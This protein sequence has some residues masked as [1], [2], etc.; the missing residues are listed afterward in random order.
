[1]DT[2]PYHAQ[3]ARPAGHRALRRSAGAAFVVGVTVTALVA[4]V[5]VAA[6]LANGTGLG[7]AKV[8]A[9]Q[10][11]TTVSA[12]PA[13]TLYPGSTGDLVVTAKNPNP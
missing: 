2:V 4:G 9:K 1:L 3:H 8:K 12:D 10:A 5:A 7:Y 13:A 6:W 11:L